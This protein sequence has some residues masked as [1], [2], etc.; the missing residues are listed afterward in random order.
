M[1]GVVFNLLE[2]FI[3]EKLEV[4]LPDA[5]RT[6]GKWLFPKLAAAVPPEMTAHQHPKEFLQ[7]V[8]NIIHVEVRKLYLDAEPPRF[9]YED[10][11][12]DRLTIH[13]QS[14][15]KL[16]DLMD[17]LLDGVAAHFDTPISF[18]RQVRQEN[19][20]EICTYELTFGA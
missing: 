13:Y 3:V 4:P 14:P 16:Y 6:F 8:E 19:E 1:K 9:D 7:T 20:V 15:R 11:G 18:S 2:E 5:L 17:G 12:P 10:P